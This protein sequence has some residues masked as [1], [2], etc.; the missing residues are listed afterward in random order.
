VTETPASSAPTKVGR[1][2]RSWDGRGEFD[3]IV[4]GS[5]IGALTTAALLAKR[6]GQ[7]VLVLERHYVAGGY[8]HVFRRPGYE[9]DVGVHYVGQLH[10]SDSTLG[11]IFNL[12]TD[13]QVDWVP[14]GDVYDRMVIAGEA[15][16]FVA[17]REPFRSAIVRYFPA[18]SRAI[19]RYLDLTQ[20]CA[21]ASRLYFAEKA[22]PSPIAWLAGGFMRWPF[23]RHARRTT[24]AVLAELTQNRELIGV[25]TGQWGDFLLPPSRS[26]F[27][28]HAII[29]EHYLEGAAYPAGGASRI[30]AAIAPIIER[31]GGRILT[32]AEVSQILVEHDRA[33]GIKLSDGREVRAG[34][35]VSGVGV[36]NTF[37]RLLPAAVAERYGLTQQL[38]VLEPSL[39]HLNLYVGLRQSARELGLDRTNLWIYPTPHHDRNL[40]AYLAD[41]AAPLPL[42][43]ISF[44]SAKDPKFDERFPGRSTIQIIAPARYDWFRSWEDQPWQRRGESYD[45]LKQQFTDRLLEQLYLHVP[46]VRGKIDHAE[47][48]TPVTTRHFANYAQGEPYGLAHT[49]SRFEQRFLK[50]RMPIGNLFLTGQD[51]TVCG[52][53]GGLASGVVCASAMLGRNLFSMARL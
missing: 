40:N 35:I 52:I 16:D 30:A 42:V 2:Y 8:T 18:E 38:R 22:V 15:Y 32:S 53:A 28:I 41:P 50:P 20:S 26:S 51:I 36:A 34:R 12:I 19:D 24:G 10:R 21:R 49:P 4:I 27:G 47:L 6:A 17:G 37:G 44:P 11:A 23:L 31:A 9:W 7:R 14:T 25:L 3:C 46:Q 29:A 39:A 33:V 5:G 1:P 45:H 48:S 13:G 43:Y